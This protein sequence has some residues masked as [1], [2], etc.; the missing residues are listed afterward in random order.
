VVASRNERQALNQFAHPGGLVMTV[1]LPILV[2]P[3]GD[4][5]VVA[6]TE[7]VT[8]KNTRE[9]SR[10]LSDALPFLRRADRVVVVALEEKGAS[11]HQAT[12]FADIVERLRLHG[13]TAECV[14]SPRLELPVSEQ[15]LGIVESQG[16]DLVV[17]GAYGHTRLREWVF[18]G[19][20]ERLLAACP[21][22][23]LF[24]R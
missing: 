17:A 14:L 11:E 22:P 12:E 8:W 13:V 2:L 18:C 10:A 15:I 6:R 19:V 9:A 21:V 1:G 24:S 3:P 16:A 23:V 7:L 20:T 5:E 4:D